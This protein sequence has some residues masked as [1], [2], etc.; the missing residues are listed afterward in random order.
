MSEVL[1]TL[2]NE[3]HNY[4]MN[5]DYDEIQFSV[6]CA[7][8]KLWDTYTAIIDQI[9]VEGNSDTLAY[10]ELIGTVFWYLWK[11]GRIEFE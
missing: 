10:T 2:S 7:D 5:K 6:F 1:L 8:F 3:C 9:C 4:F 11:I